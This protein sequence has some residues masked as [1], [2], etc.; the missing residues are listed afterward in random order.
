[1]NAP[2]LCRPLDRLAAGLLIGAAALVAG[3]RNGWAQSPPTNAPASTKA[4]APSNA[5]APTNAQAPASTKPDST[6]KK[7]ASAKVAARMPM[8][9]QPE[10]STER[11]LPPT[12]RISTPKEERMT[13]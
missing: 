2:S 11:K 5:Q 13:M 12:P 9:D 8:T 6:A 7:P 10:R 1:M 3:G 4:Q